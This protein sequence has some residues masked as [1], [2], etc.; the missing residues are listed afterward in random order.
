MVV[1]P[2]VGLKFPEN[3]VIV[4][5]ADWLLPP[6]SVRRLDARDADTAQVADTVWTT[7]ILQTTH[8]EDANERV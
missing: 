5:Y 2:N 6:Q 1:L 3:G 4:N 7:E 8:A